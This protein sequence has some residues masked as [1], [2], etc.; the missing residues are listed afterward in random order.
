MTIVTRNLDFFSFPLGAEYRREKP[1]AE[2]AVERLSFAMPL[3][4]FHEIPSRCPSKANSTS[5]ENIWSW[6]T[7]NKEHPHII[8]R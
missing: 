6:A 7:P 8:T 1:F 4:H 5:P 2:Q 3:I